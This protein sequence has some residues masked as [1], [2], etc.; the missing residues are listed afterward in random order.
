MPVALLVLLFSLCGTDLAAQVDTTGDPTRPVTTHPR[1]PL[2]P[3][4]DPFPYGLYEHSI[5]FDSVGGGVTLRGYLALPICRD[6]D[7]T[8]IYLRKDVE[9]RVDPPR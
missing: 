2:S 1:L 6:D 3:L 8:C 4:S 5:F 7:G 9:I